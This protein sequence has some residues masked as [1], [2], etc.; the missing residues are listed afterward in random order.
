MY[1]D[2]LSCTIKRILILETSKKYSTIFEIL[3]ALNVIYPQ[4]QEMSF[5]V[6]NHKQ[7]L[8]SF[9]VFMHYAHMLFYINILM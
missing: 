9:F 1:Q 2:N 3:F 6:Q 4:I 8:S 5:I 7:L